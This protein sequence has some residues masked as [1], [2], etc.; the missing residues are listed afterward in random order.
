M[1]PTKTLPLLPIIP[2]PAT[3]VLAT[4]F[5]PPSYN[6][7]PQKPATVPLKDTQHP[8]LHPA[9]LN[10]LQPICYTNNNQNN[11]HLPNTTPTPSVFS[12]FYFERFPSWIDYQD[13]KKAFS[14]ISPVT[15]LFI[16]SK[17][18][19]IGRRFGFVTFFSI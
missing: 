19:K 16:S 18:T 15:N 11:K 4:S 2:S 10:F 9:T 14:N 6:P 8:P 1:L 7:T 5:K 12:K 3:Q 17:K 13:L